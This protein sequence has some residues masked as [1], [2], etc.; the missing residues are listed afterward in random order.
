MATF[1]QGDKT[2][3]L[4]PRESSGD[5]SGPSGNQSGP[6]EA[7]AACPSQTTARVAGA[8]EVAPLVTKAASAACLKHLGGPAI[9]VRAI[10]PSCSKRRSGSRN[11]C[12]GGDDG[13]TM[14]R[15]GS[16]CLSMATLA[17]QQKWPPLLA[18][19]CSPLVSMDGRWPL[20]AKPW[21][22]GK[23]SLCW[24]RNATTASEDGIYHSEVDHI[25][26]Q[27]PDLVR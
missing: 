12:D 4:F 13:K 22:N 8:S 9:P 2:G 16:A 21:P 27:G 25:L 23:S 7:T 10:G 6:P 3:G 11:R 18:I 20:S 26:G 17:Y 1:R 15:C 19:A 14:G 5:R 24:G